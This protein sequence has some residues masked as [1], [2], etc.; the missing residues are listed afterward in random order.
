MVPTMEY[1]AVKCPAYGRR[2]AA[3]TASAKDE[4][5]ALEPSLLPARIHR[6]FLI[7]HAALLHRPSSHCNHLASGIRSSNKVARGMTAC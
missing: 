5:Q 6:T 7:S 1:S 4:H 3:A 2:L